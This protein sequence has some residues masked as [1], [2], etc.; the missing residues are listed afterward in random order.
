VRDQALDWFI[1]RQSQF[2]PLQLT[3]AGLYQSEVFPGLWLDPAALI[4]FNLARALQVVQQG[5][6]TPEHAALVT[7]LQQAASGSP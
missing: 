6:A 4:R 3:P 2:Q 5:L 7:H 1:L